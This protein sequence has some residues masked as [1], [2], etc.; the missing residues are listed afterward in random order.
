[1]STIIYNALSRVANLNPC[2]GGIGPGMLRIIVSECRDALAKLEAYDEALPYLQ[3][4]EAL[5]FPMEQ[6]VD[7]CNNIG[8]GCTDEVIAAGAALERLYRARVA[9]RDKAGEQS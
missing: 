6:L 5:E 1:M 8:H 9:A 2:C 7:Y 4:L 3:E